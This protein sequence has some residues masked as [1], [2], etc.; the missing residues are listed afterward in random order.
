MIDDFRSALQRLSD[1]GWD[2]IFQFLGVDPRSATF[3]ED[4]LKPVDR[5]AVE[6]ALMPGFGDVAP[7]SVR[8]IEPGKPAHSLLFHALSSPGVIE[9]PDGTGLGSFPTAAD[10]ELAENV[11]FGLVPPTLQSIISGVGNVA[12][13]SVAVF[14]RDYRQSSKTVHGKHADLVFSR[15]GI[16]RVGTKEAIWDGKRRCYLPRDATDD[17]FGF[18][19]LPC[20]YGVYL[21]VQL[22]GDDG[23]FG[24]FKF[25]R[26]FELGGQDVSIP[27][28][29]LDFWVPVHK[30]FSG[31]D[32]LLGTSLK[33]SLVDHHIS[34]KV[35]RI[36]NQNMGAGTLGGFESGFKPPETDREPFLLRSELA[37]FMDVI[38]HGQGVLAPVVRDRLIEPTS[39]DGKLVGTKVP[40]RT[41]NGLS[42]SFLTPGREPGAHGSPEWMHV[43]SRLKTDG[44]VENLNEREDV[45]G[46]V[47]RAT[48]GSV[49]NY[50]AV[51][52]TDFT[53]DGWIDA[54]VEGLGSNLDRM[55]PAYSVIAA[56]DFYPFVDQS[57]LLDWWRTQVP[58]DLR[59]ALWSVPPLTLADQRSAGNIN[60]RSHG[61]DI[62]PAN[63]TPSAIIG[64]KGS[65][66][67]AQSFGSEPEVP[68]VSSLPDAG[69]GIYQPG[70][71]VSTDVTRD[72]DLAQQVLHLAA[73]GLGSPFPEDAKLC[74]ALS[75]FWPGVAPDAA[76][77]AG[78]RAIAPMTD[79]EVGLLDQPAWDGILGPRR[80]SV[81]TTD[82]VETDNFDHVDY[83]STALDGKFTM[84]E[85]MRVS[86]EDYQ[87]RVLATLRMHL[88]VL[89][90]S[91]NGTDAPPDL[92]S[93]RI[94]SFSQGREGDA[95]IHDAE[96]A[97]GF[98]FD[99]RA[100]R[101]QVA[102]VGAQM[103]LVRDS[104]NRARWLKREPIL[105][106]IEV[107]VGV[108][109]QIAFR[110]K[111][112]NWQLPE[113]LVG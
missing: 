78:F 76:R 42:P 89:N 85:T 57:A 10:L 18:R 75:A 11:V 32:C 63:K 2:P 16:V 93:L 79:R 28:S 23:D 21:A 102:E 90:M 26:A 8:P 97:L 64:L 86:Q 99:E 73:Y 33:V 70:W 68:R 38:D 71:D 50:T 31:T 41:H 22:K 101:Y 17:P 92:S 106:E 54:K 104:T 12:K 91:G 1:G 112:E 67:T 87:F 96:D 94:V 36:H 95:T 19:V 13:L 40:S 100:C 44:G 6:I 4:L 83:V 61:A 14:A 43:R 37:A 48:V 69:A 47:R 80:V 25:N 105:R 15:T 103:P 52:Y 30:L 62:R 46:I 3:R 110:R 35:R 88:L 34:E 9:T 55:V 77:S 58:T 60:L 27:D 7:G 82:F 49:R 51:H 59:Q 53:G 107:I 24:P 81:G 20:R 109:E 66:D 108:N 29:E 45:S 72:A 39:V 113:P 84:A 74:A 111:D 98:Q 5:T 65:A 56:P